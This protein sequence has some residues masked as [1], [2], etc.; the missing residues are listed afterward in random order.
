MRIG[1][2]VRRCVSPPIVAAARRHWRRF[3]LV[4]LGVGTTAVRRQ[5]R[6]SL[7]SATLTYC[8]LT[9]ATTRSPCC[10]PLADAAAAHNIDLR[11]ADWTTRYRLS[12]ESG[13]DCA[14][15]TT[16]VVVLSRANDA[17]R[18]AAIRATWANATVSRDE[19]AAQ[20]TVSR[21]LEGAADRRR[22]SLHRR[23]PT[24]ASN[25]GGAA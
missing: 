4:L 6:R 8:A 12:G 7:I 21:S 23:R 25:R 22:R 3:L 2:A 13:N 9:L 11:F 1:C 18:R 16:L 5:P 15:A 19:A 14:N 17:A 20:R 24:I 10:E